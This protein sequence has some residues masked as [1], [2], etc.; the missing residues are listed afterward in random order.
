[1]Y[2]LEREATHVVNR[3]RWRDAF[4]IFMRCICCGLLLLCATAAVRSQDGSP[5]ATHKHAEHRQ[6]EADVLGE[7]RRMAIPDVEILNQDGQKR[8][9][10]TDLVK[11]KLVVINFVFTTCTDICPLS[12]ETFAKLQAS[13]GARLGKEVHLL[14]ISTDPETDSPLK[15]KAWSERFKPQAG[16]T[17]VT[18]E[19][20]AMQ[21]LLLALTGEGARR[22]YHTP[23][24]LL[25][26]GESGVWVRTYGLESPVRLI[27]M[28]E[29]LSVRSERR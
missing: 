28:L 26:N 27:Q 19:K 3:K 7:T 8:R 13:L 14:S 23:V 25:G 6:K 21:T 29:A 22:G 24:A 17:F 18:G 12:G 9:F 16:W 5:R 11:G 1:M 2:T 15:L 10:Y 20:T 4:S